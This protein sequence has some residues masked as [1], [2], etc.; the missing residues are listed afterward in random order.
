MQGK[1]CMWSC[2]LGWCWFVWISI[3]A[4]A[5]HVSVSRAQGNLSEFVKRKPE[6]RSYYELASA[7]G[8]K[9]VLPEPGFLEGVKT[10][11]R[12]ILK[13]MKVAFK[14]APAPHPI[15]LNCSCCASCVLSLPA[16]PVTCLANRVCRIWCMYCSN[17]SLLLLRVAK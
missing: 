6:A 3:C 5:E 4:C 13:M 10:K 1:A 9:F 17:L 14:C 15:S 12:P 8:L 2:T 16:L 7:Q 11:D